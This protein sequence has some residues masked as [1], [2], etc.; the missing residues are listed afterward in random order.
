VRVGKTVQ[1]YQ[2]EPYECSLTSV[3][4]CAD[5]IKG[6]DIKLEAERLTA[7][8]SALTEAELDKV[9]KKSAK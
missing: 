6:S 9:S 8:V 4:E 5:G 3:L 2:Y 1:L 7:L